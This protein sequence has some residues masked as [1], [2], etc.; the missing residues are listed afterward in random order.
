MAKNILMDLA[1]ENFHKCMGI[2]D[3]VGGKKYGWSNLSGNSSLC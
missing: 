2:S 3:L 1:F